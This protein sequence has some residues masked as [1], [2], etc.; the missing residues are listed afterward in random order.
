MNSVKEI[1][2]KN[3]IDNYFDEIIN[4]KNLN[5]NKL[6]IDEKIFPYTRSVILKT[7]NDRCK[8]VKILIFCSLC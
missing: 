7:E 6:K 8:I 4:I 3:D 2:V 5:P 1:N